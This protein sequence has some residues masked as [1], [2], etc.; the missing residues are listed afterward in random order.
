MFA[1]TFS[2]PF[3]PFFLFAGETA[4][5]PAGKNKGPDFSMSASQGF[6]QS[7]LLECTGAWPLCE[8]QE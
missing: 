6:R 5:E 4:G 3:P 1:F 8:G 2:D 7:F